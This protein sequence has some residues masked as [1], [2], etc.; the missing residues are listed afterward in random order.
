MKKK[1]FTSIFLFTFFA[2]LLTANAFAIEPVTFPIMRIY[3]PE[4]PFVHRNTWQN[5]TISIEN[6][7]YAMEATTRVRG[8]G[9][10][11]WWDGEGKRPLRFRLD[12]AQSIM[13]S[14]YIARDWILLADKFDRSL[15]RNRSALFLAREMGSMSFVPTFHHLHLYVNGEYMGVYLLT[16]ERDTSRGRLEIDWHED[17]RRSGFFLELD[18]RAPI[19]GAENE[20]YVIVNNLPYDL[21]WPSDERMT[22]EHVAYVRGFLD[23][24]SFAIREQSFEEIL[25][26]I[27]LDTFV[28]FYILQE[29]YRNKDVYMLS[30]FMHITGESGE[31]RLFMGPVWDFDM[32]AANSP[33]Q[34][35]GSGTD[36]LYV[37]IFNYWYR[38]L[39]Q[40]PEFFDAVAS[41]WNELYPTAI[42]DTIAH[43]RDNAIRYRNEFERNFIRHPYPAPF[44]RPDFA[45]IN[46]FMQ[47]INYLADWL[48]NRAAWLN[49]F[50]SREFPD[51][52][53][54]QEF[55]NFYKYDSPIT[56]EINGVAQE[57]EIPAIRLPYTTKIALPELARILNLQTSQNA[58][59]ITMW[60]DDTSIV[61]RIGT[62]VFTIN[63]VRFDATAS[64]VA[65][66]DHIF[67]PLRVIA[68]ALGYN[69]DWVEAQQAV[70]L[71]R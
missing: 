21:R 19:S 71:R 43:I 65:I 37:A 45:E 62:D 17:P 52:C 48:E 67:I 33:T 12:Q 46:T 14:E 53:H 41:R 11:T 4:S 25:R 22:P 20:T 54:M 42:T 6:S 35:M 5:G 34:W 24:T 44:L 31:R 66:L 28:D 70:T 63:G 23:V 39:M 50:F 47:Q 36:G 13:G 61:H 15:M 1:I 59:N 27:D 49:S 56:I 16:D 58:I 10:S 9:N 3:V 69:V 32:A 29:L 57:F 7:P 30:V 2:F 18:G 51:Y 40:H 64:S 60:N 8:R 68:E 55:L 38:H 26:R